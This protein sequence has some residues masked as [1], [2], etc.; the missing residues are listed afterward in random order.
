[1][2]KSKG[3]AVD[4]MNVIRGASL[5]DL[6]SSLRQN[7]AEGLLNEHEF[8]AALAEQ[9]AA[10]PSG[11]P[12]CGADALRLT[13]LYS[14]VKSDRVRIDVDRARTMAAFANKI[15]Q[16]TRFVTQHNP[17]PIASAEPNLERA[18]RPID[19]WI[20]SQLASTVEKCDVGLRNYD[21]HVAV[22]ALYEFWYGA[23]CDV[24]LEACKSVLWGPEC[25][26]KIGVR[27]VLDVCLDAG[28][29][30]LFPFMPHVTD[31]LFH[32]YHRRCGASFQPPCESLIRAPYPVPEKWKQFKNPDLD[33]AFDEAFKLI[34]VLRKH[35]LGLKLGKVRPDVAVVWP[36]MAGH[37]VAQFRDVIVDL[38]KVNSLEFCLAE[39]DVS[40]GFL[41]LAG[42]YPD[43][44]VFM[45]VERLNVDEEIARRLVNIQKDLDGLK[46]KINSKKFSKIVPSR[47]LQ[48]EKKYAALEFER[49][50]L[51]AAVKMQKS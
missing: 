21:F 33:A 43:V 42:P 16:A 17:E 37:V 38:A 27:A 5:D 46:E 31:E 41:L 22:A 14:D 11:I 19:A 48:I 2:S 49:E 6:E 45:N 35:K 26:V 29:R 50:Q 20:L 12:V 18:K 10:F 4:P 40:N 1:M 39:A 34:E 23:F 8:S 30:L 47:R 24:Y 36:N 25:D 13:L 51:A 32:R 7:K 44:N 9:N 15:W 3:N 28:L